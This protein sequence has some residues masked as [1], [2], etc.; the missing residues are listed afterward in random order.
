MKKLATITETKVS[1]KVE[2][3][4]SLKSPP[5][6]SEEQDL[7][8][9]GGELLTEAHSKIWERYKALILSCI[10]SQDIYEIGDES[11]VRGFLA[12][13][14]WRLKLSEKMDEINGRRQRRR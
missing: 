9:M 6:T 10:F 4:L 3:E 1:R 14:K 5:L 12:G 13:A 11:Y 2:L 7:I 8:H